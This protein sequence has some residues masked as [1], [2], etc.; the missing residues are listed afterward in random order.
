MAPGEEV[1]FTLKQLPRYSSTIADQDYVMGEQQQ[2]AA[3]SGLLPPFGLVVTSPR[4]T[5]TTRSEKPWECHARS[6]LC[7]RLAGVRRLSYVRGER[8]IGGVYF[9]SCDERHHELR[10]A[11]LNLVTPYQTYLR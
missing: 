2:A 4:S 8:T 10:I 1:A 7:C 6:R 9:A 3:Q 5:I 11:G